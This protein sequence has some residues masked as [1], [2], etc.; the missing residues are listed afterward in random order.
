M[1]SIKL[2]LLVLLLSP[3]FAVAQ[4]IYE[5]RFVAEMKQYRAALVLYD[6]GIGKMRVRY[7]EPGQGTTMVEQTMRVENTAYG[8]RVTGYNPVYPGTKV[9]Y[10]SYTPDNF[11]ISQNEYGNLI[12][13][14]VDDRGTT[15]R[16][17]I[18]VINGASAQRSL[19]SEFDWELR[20]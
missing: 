15:A 5:V 14:N 11:Y 20:W 18:K 3:V 17:S 19:L 10:P 6:S 9:R 12:I 4:S 7:Y 8:Y 16:T 2:S 1:K 13:T